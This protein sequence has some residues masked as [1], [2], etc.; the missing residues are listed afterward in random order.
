MQIKIDLTLFTITFNN[1]GVFSSISNNEFNLDYPIT[2]KTPLK[3]YKKNSI[4]IWAIY[5]CY[6]VIKIKL[7]W[8][9]NA[10]DQEVL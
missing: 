1:N 4:I 6:S 3:S 2:Y 8:G 9:I 10:V 5:Q 7:F